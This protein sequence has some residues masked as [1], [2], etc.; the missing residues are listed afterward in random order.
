MIKF[1]E[2]R[3][4]LSSSSV[5]G[6]TTGAFVATGLSQLI[7]K[8]EAAELGKSTGRYVSKMAE[9]AANVI[10]SAVPKVMSTGKLQS[11][12]N[13]I[14]SGIKATG[15]VFGSRLRSTIEMFV[16]PKAAIIKGAIIGAAIAAG[17]YI[18][19]YLYNKADQSI[20]SSR[21]NS[22][23][24]LS[25]V[26]RYLRS[27]GYSNEKDYALDPD[28]A[29]YIR[30]KVSIV[31]DKNSDNLCLTI[32][33][34]NDPKLEKVTK[35]IIKELPTESRFYSKQ[36]D[37]NNELILHVTSSNGGDSVYVGEIVEKF[38][39]KKYPVFLVEIN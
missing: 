9:S 38:I 21:I 23:Y 8:K 7:G 20:S 1:V 32:N 33:S 31:V 34:V 17:Y 30:T 11:V 25:E 14:S 36:S 27:K 3:Y 13:A 19:K 37:K 4:S 35:S 24:S 16:N 18:I 6:A 10:S 15:N 29:D 12:A 26:D 5:K 2:K 39:Q 22:N 28:T